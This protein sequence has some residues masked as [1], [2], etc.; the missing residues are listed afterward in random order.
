MGRQAP[1]HARGKDRGPLDKPT[2]KGTE[3]E[4]P[5]QSDG[6]PPPS[7]ATFRRQ[8]SDKRTER[9]PRTGR[10]PGRE[11]RHNPNGRPAVAGGEDPGNDPLAAATPHRR[12]P[13]PPARPSH[14]TASEHPAT[15]PPRPAVHDAAA[16]VLS[17]RELSAGWVALYA[18]TFLLQ[19]LCA[20]VRALVSYP[21]LWVAV[22]VTKPILHLGTGGLHTLAF[23]AGYGPLAI[24]L[25]TL[26]VPVGGWWW[27]QR[28]GA[29]APSER[30][31]L[32]Y[33][34]ALAELKHADPRLRPPRRWC[35]LDEGSTNAA[36]Y[37]DTLMVNRGL[38]E[39]PYITPVMAHELGHLNT[40]DAR[41]TA[42]LTRLTTPPRKYIRN[43]AMHAIA[44]VA[45]GAAA[46]WVTK[47]PWAA[48][49][50]EREYEADKYAAK[51]GQA[52]PLAM[53]L[54]REALEYDLPN[55]FP[56]M[57]GNG[58]PPTEHR[59]DRIEHLMAVSRRTAA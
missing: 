59:I 42:A 58:H 36:V 27:Q 16:Y 7:L 52:R 9:P 11:P 12:D 26:V 4:T 17:P 5:G 40:S 53:F 44:L 33:E 57:R 55:P 30:E 49:W 21:L 20:S 45:T 23:L 28:A 39:S 6:K 32:I 2:G 22:K 47:L 24:S 56:W 1:L 8:R 43:R 35:V 13:K 3:G 18:G 41:L 14:D 51:L 37:A 54:D 31:R 50:R 19:T 10:P 34:D 15:S 38:L 25:A 29:R 48:Y 46:V